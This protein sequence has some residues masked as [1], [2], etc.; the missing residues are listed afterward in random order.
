MF[1]L[2]NAIVGLSDALTLML[3]ARFASG[4]GYGI[5]LAVAS[6]VATQFTGRHGAGASEGVL[7]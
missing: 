2:G 1:T 3:V 7:F 6:S 5:F 4:L